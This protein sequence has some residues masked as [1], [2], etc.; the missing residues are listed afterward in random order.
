[1]RYEREKL[2][3]VVA[4]MILSLSALA[5]MALVGGPRLDELLRRWAPVGGNVW[6]RVIVLG[7]VY[8]AGLGL[9][10]LP[11]TFRSGYV[12]EHRYQLSN[13]TFRGWLWRQIKG[14]LVGGPVG[15]VLLLGLYALLWYGGPLWWL[16]AT[17]G[18][19]AVTLLLGRLLPV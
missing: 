6:L 17:L 8:A 12:L 3:A 5:F 15:L 16:W 18:W 10:S 11:I 13:Q 19:L 7:F 4:A 1:K 9:L 14:Y 2:I